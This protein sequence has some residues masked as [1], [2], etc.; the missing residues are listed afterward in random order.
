M[1]CSLVN[2]QEKKA[3]RRRIMMEGVVE[4]TR[5][6]YELKLFPMDDGYIGSLS[7]NDGNRS[8]SSSSQKECRTVVILDRSGS[9]CD[10]V[11]KITNKV[12][13]IVFEN[14][15]Y[16]PNSEIHLITFDSD[17]EVYTVN[18]K[19]LQNL[20]IDCRGCTNMAGA[21]KEFHE[22]FTTFDDNQPIRLLTISDGEVHDEG[23]VIEAG[24]EL[25]KLVS[26]SKTSINSQAVRLF[27]SS[28]Q[29]DTTALCSLLQV[30]NVKSSQLADIS[31]SLSEQEIATQMTQ[32][33]I[34]DGFSNG[35][36][37]TSST[38]MFSKYPWD[39]KL[40]DKLTLITG[41]NVFW[42]K[43]APTS[44]ILIEETP[45]KVSIQPPPS[46]STFHKLM[47]SKLDYIVG[48]VKILKLVENEVA[49]QT[50]KRICKYFEEKEKMLLNEPQ[51]MDND[52]HLNNRARKILGVRRKKITLLLAT[53]ANDDNV[54]QLNSAQK[55]DYLRQ[56]EISKTS[57][58]LAKRAANEGLNFDEI[59]R[60]EVLEMA[61]HFD[62][63]KDVDDSGHAVSFFS[64][65]TTLGGLKSLVEISQDELF[66]TVEV[67]E[68]LELMNLVGVACSGPIGD[69]PD[70]MTWNVSDI[71][72]GCYVS[73]SDVLVAFNQSNGSSLM[74]PAINK[75]I[76]NVIPFFD[77]PKIGRFLKK[78]AP[79]LL[80]Y[81]FSVGMRRIIA[82]VPMTIGYTMCAGIWKMIL[83]LNKKKSTLHLEIFQNLTSTFDKFV[84]TYFDHVK[85]FLTEQNNGKLSFYIGYNGISNMMS[86][87]MRIYQ[88]RD[89]EKIKLMPKI[90]RTLYSFEVWQGI[91]R[92]YKNKDD[93]EEIAK[94][95]L[96]KLLGI[97]MVKHKVEVKPLYDQEPTF[98]EIKFYDEPAFDNDYLAEL[99]KPLFYIDYLTLIPTCLDAA[100]NNNLDSIKNMPA[101]SNS[102]VLKSLE[103]SYDY[104]EFRSMNAFQALLYTTRMDRENSEDKVMKIVDLF[105]QQE[106]IDDIK[107]YIRKQFETQYL[108]D[109]A[110]KRKSE[111]EQMGK[112][113]AQ[114]ILESQTYEEMIHIWKNGLKLNESTFLIE[115]QSSSGFK[116]LCHGLI[117]S[118]DTVPLRSNIFKVLL[119]GVDNEGHPVWNRGG[120]CF[121]HNMKAL[122]ESFLKFHSWNEWNLIM[123]D[124][125]AR[126]VHIYRDERV[127][128]KGH[129]NSK[130]SFWAMGHSTFE[131]YR[132]SVSEDIFRQYCRNHRMC[133]GV[134]DLEE[135]FLR[136]L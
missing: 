32:L 55:A 84:G 103:I 92:H 134:R 60:A 53:I 42:M 106:A 24:A 85:P 19:G 67:N 66:E 99:Y 48:H 81:T 18:I 133:C 124:F 120:V 59:A 14:L 37:M 110:K 69:Y 136:T 52:N 77:D 74:A 95:M 125:K 68:I 112:K 4:N 75:E 38:P 79:S 89:D 97:D 63:L 100:V 13:P 121:V 78:Y 83:S 3:K 50:L 29:P 62:E 76:T 86:P 94:N 107:K 65:D 54:G 135:K 23:E 36:P 131:D 26:S 16:D 105:D 128:R 118:T 21:V 127:N 108:S 129:G 35:L 111:C 56:T 58:G 101:L 117:E 126:G 80:E 64:R 82:D 71:F 7:I 9:M 98:D 123:T 87:L 96:Y 5:E 102:L 10:N 45:V 6:P 49:A 46:L 34:D 119:L 2:S 44:E 113:I 43:Q 39:E 104:D 8:N 41:E 17:V 88:S 61:K 27:T 122:K 57:R 31:A 70:P 116:H 130:P 40:L 1:F 90:L 30:N 93:S 115:T 72:V 109:L 12:L 33:F 114:S 91:R 25:S 47:D 73:L 132:S 11:A 20:P 28:C 15:S 22:L 51:E